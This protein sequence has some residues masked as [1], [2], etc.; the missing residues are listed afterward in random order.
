MMHL[1]ERINEILSRHLDKSIKIFRQ[2]DSFPADSFPEDSSPAD[3]SP[4]EISY[5]LRRYRLHSNYGSF[6]EAQQRSDDDIRQQDIEE[7]SRRQNR[8]SIHQFN[9]FQRNDPEHSHKEDNQYYTIVCKRDNRYNYN[10]I[11]FVSI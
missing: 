2:R 9:V 1:E 4:G 5:E 8:A 11:K 10:V 6:D 7:V 3:S